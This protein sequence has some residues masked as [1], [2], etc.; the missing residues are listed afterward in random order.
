MAAWPFPVPTYQ[1]RMK[2]SKRK[3]ESMGNNSR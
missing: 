3:Q 1:A 2:V